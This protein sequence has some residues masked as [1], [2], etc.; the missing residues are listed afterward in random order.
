MK[1]T[2][3]M[4]IFKNSRMKIMT[5]EGVF[6]LKFLNDKGEKF[7]STKNGKVIV[8]SSTGAPLYQGLKAKK[9]YEQE[10]RK[11]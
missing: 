5:E 1:L 9:Y 11:S 10:M 6:E 4:C 3:L 8:E 7:Y 2:K